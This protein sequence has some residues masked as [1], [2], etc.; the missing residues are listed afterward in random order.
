MMT[1]QIPTV[2][3]Q[4]NA[5]EKGLG[6]AYLWAQ[7]GHVKPECMLDACVS[8][9]RFD[10][11]CEDARGDWLWQIL[12]AGSFVEA[13]RENLLHELHGIAQSDAATQL[14]QLARH[15][16]LTGDDRFKDAL[17]IIV[18]DKLVADCDWIGEEEL[19]RLEG[20]DGFLAAVRRHGKELKTRTWD[21]YDSA[22]GDYGVKWLGEDRTLQLLDARSPADSSVGRFS[23]LW[24]THRVEQEQC[25][26]APRI[27]DTRNW[28]VDEVIAA[29]E[30][31]SVL[32]TGLRRWGR[33]ASESDVARVYDRMLSTENV[34]ALQ[35]YLQI[36]AVR[37]WP[38]YDA[39]MFELCNHTDG[40]VS[41]WSRTA[42][43]K[44]RHPE[45]RRRALA[46]LDEPSDQGDAIKMLSTNYEPGDER[47]VLKVL[48]LPDDEWELHST[49]MSLDKLLDMNPSAAFVEACRVIYENTPCSICRT[50]AVR[51]LADRGALSTEIES[52]C[53]FDV[54][55]GT[56]EI[57]GG[58]EWN[59]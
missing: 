48:S 37:T 17:R 45:V 30:T 35:R 6:R 12:V 23:E 56:R 28:S 40:R 51:L 43:S 36:F 57:V 16:A 11:Q 22:L 41:R 31:A 13:V 32:A 19:V 27:D 53:R 3:D 18:V 21:W 46:M 29:A 34:A 55:A 25:D 26:R 1:N 47:R 14:C 9:Y 52:E 2:E 7:A 54:D 20:D 58:P 10:R 42:V 50:G 39:R 38:R 5:L 24:Q 33:F 15:F 8:D 59:D 4:T 44:N 49:L